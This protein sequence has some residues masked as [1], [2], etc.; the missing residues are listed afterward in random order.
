MS[1]AQPIRHVV[2][3][4]DDR[5]RDLMIAS[6][7]AH[8]LEALGIKVHLEPLE[9]Y[10]GCLAAW[11]P[12]LILFNHL[13]ASHLAAYSR[14]LHEMGVLTAVLPN[15]GILYDQEEMRFNSGRHHTD[16]HIDLFFCWNE[17]HRQAL[18]ESG[19]GAKSR[20]EVVGVPRFDF[21]IEPWSRLYQR[22]RLTPRQRPRLLLCTNFITAK[23]RELPREHGDRFFAAWK[24]RIPLYHDYWGGIEAH[25]KGRA[26]ALDF[27][28]ELAACGR[29]D[30]TLRPH[31]REEKDFYENFLATLPAEQ[32]ALVTLDHGGSITELILD[33]DL[34]VS[35]ETCTTALESWIAGKPTVEIDLERHPLWHSKEAAASGL[36]C[37]DPAKLVPMV[38]QALHSP[39]PPELAARRRAHLQK[40]CSATDGKST[41]R[42]ARVLADALAKKG[43]T[44][45]SSLTMVDRRRAVKL[46]VLHDLGFAYHFDPFMPLKRV[47]FGDRYAIKDYSLRKSIRPGDVKQA[48]AQLAGLGKSSGA[49]T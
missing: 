13:T 5:T 45:W 30:L 8:H 49:A 38:E 1:Q 19:F 11:R 47:V 6:L 22:P 12:D 20:I 43:P 3:L 9:A 28:R 33:C 31:P 32:R 26:R 41:E 34:E 46:R 7:V 36:A 4:V 21:Y 2:I 27:F 48:R 18:C 14:R 15:E 39:A 17:Q 29:Y 37:D 42:M 44:D 23:F 25:H 16:A 24:D 40:W 35:I 10:Q